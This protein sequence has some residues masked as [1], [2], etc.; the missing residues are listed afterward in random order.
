MKITLLGTGTSQGV[1]VIGCTCPVCQSADTRDQRLRTSAF[2]E[3]GDTKILIDTGPDLRTQLLRANISKVDGILLTHEHKD[4]LAGLD[5]IRPVYFLRNSPMEV[6]GLHRVLS[7]V[8]KDFDYAFKSNPYPGA[9]AFV[10]HTVRDDV[11]TVKDVEVTPIHVRHL[12]LPI[13]GYRIQN[14]AYITDA[15]FI[16]ETELN[17]LQNLDVLVVN[18]LRLREHYS[19]FNLDQALHLIDVLKPKRAFLTHISH[20]M[21][22]YAEAAERIPDNV[23]LGY[24]GLT[25]EC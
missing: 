13:L 23:L 6:Y 19:H 17:K 3:V 7:V 18:A 10:L 24:D 2:V 25:V 20:E 15:S 12:T 14:M 9:P 21:G 8:R 16:A 11:F 5:D 1:P 22:K 4:H